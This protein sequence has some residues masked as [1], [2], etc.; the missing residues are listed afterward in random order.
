MRLRREATSL[1]G[2][3]RQA[4]RPAEV[5]PVLA[6][7]EIDQ[8]RQRVRGAGREPRAA[9]AT[10][11]AVSRVSSPAGERAREADGGA[12]LGQLAGHDAAP[13]DRLRAREVAR[14]APRSGRR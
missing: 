13:E 2:R 8:D 7:V 9:R 6:L 5:H 12:H 10:A 4:D 1:A 3:D 11:S 14:C